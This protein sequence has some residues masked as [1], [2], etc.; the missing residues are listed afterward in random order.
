MGERVRGKVAIV[1]GAGTFGSGMGNGKASAILYAREGAQVMAV[2]CN[3]K[4]AEETRQ[5]IAE[6]GGNCVVFKA[7][8]T[9]SD[10]CRG[11]VEECIDTFGRIDILHNN[12]G[13]GGVGDAMETSEEMWDRIININLRSMFLTC[14]HVLP[15]MEKQG[16]GSIVNISSIASIRMMQ[17]PTTAYAVS[18]AGVNALTRELAIQ[19]AAKGIRVN[20]ILPGYMDTPVMRVAIE[21]GHVGD[22]DAILKKRASMIPIQALGNAWDTAYAA[23]FLASDE[24]KYITGTVLVVDGGLTDTMRT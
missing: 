20:A 16:S 17:F 6:E 7:D 19:Y 11:I 3:L 22:V 24:A 23:L 10:D 2:D 5:L 12:V 1:T 15:Y 18:K 8:V 4:A 13:V 21:D 9:K 14:R